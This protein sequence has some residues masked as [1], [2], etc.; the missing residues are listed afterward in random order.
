[1]AVDV[2]LAFAILVFSVSRTALAAARGVTLDTARAAARA[3]ALA[4]VVVAVLVPTSGVALAGALVAVSSAAFRSA[5]GRQFSS[6]TECEEAEGARSTI[7][8]CS[9][10]AEGARGT[11]TGCFLRGVEQPLSKWLR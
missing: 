2:V 3:A 6:H 4:V 7:R 11:T 5:A 10:R 8:S 9:G 1:M